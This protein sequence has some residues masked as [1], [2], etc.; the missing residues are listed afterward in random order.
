MARVIMALVLRE[1]R[2]RFGRQRL[3]YVWAVVEPTAYV[4]VFVTMLT[5]GGKHLPAG[6]PAIPFLITGVIPFFLFRDSMLRSMSAIQANYP[7]LTFPQVKPLDLVLGRAL[8]ET[9]T[10][11]FV[12]VAL[13]VGAMAFGSPVKIE[14]PLAVLFWLPTV[15]FLGFGAGALFGAFVPMFPAIERLVPSVFTRPLLF[16]SGVFFTADMVPGAVREYALFNP[17]LHLI[18]LLRSAFFVEFESVYADRS[19]AL[20]FAATC[21][22]LGLLCQRAMR[23]RILTTARL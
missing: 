10:L 19:Y 21:M 14:D 12:F 16:I 1:M 18:D 4:L 6:M 8:L 11:M 7:L 23:N 5:L 2:T 17:L 15:A 13:L 9:V 20:F 3:G 22:L